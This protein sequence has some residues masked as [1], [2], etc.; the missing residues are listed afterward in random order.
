MKRE[1]SRSKDVVAVAKTKNRGAVVPKVEV[2][3][4]APLEEGEFLEIN[5]A[6]GVFEDWCIG[7]GGAPQP[8]GPPSRSKVEKA[9]SKWLKDPEEDWGV[10]DAEAEH[11]DDAVNEIV[12]RLVGRR[13]EPPEGVRVPPPPPP[14]PPRATSSASG[15]GGGGGTGKGKGKD[16][17]GKDG[18]GKEG[19]GRQGQG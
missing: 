4:E 12:D 2:E 19:Q 15:S 13:L 3:K 18:K 7:S 1:A 8:A 16:G 11:N 10:V 9:A 17:K 6:E 5:E 14:A